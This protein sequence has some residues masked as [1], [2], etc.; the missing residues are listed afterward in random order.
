VFDFGQEDDVY[1]IVM[2]YVQG[3]DLMDVLGKTNRIPPEIV[4]ALLEEVSYGLE[5]AHAQGVIHRDI[6]PSN[7]MLSESGEVKIADFGLARQS[8]DIAR[9]SALTLPGSVLGTPAYM[10]PEQAAGKDVDQ[11][12]DIYSLG[13]MAYE[14]FT[15][16]KP[17]IGS[18]YSEIRDQIINHEPPALQG[19]AAVTPEVEALVHRMLAKDP[20]R[21]YPSVRHVIRA[22]ED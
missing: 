4:L 7:V 14:L 6:K 15:G 16:K 17:F 5:A 18:S 11:R 20:D 8:S 22:I 3:M 9:L 1:Y 13:V 21:R 10:S 19:E 12:T 2:E